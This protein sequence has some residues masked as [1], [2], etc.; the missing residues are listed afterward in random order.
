MGTDLSKICDGLKPAMV[1]VVVQIVFAG[2]NV[3]YKLATNDGMNM[4]ILVAYRY[5]FATAFVAPLAFFLERKT[6]PKLTWTVV[7]QGFLCGLFGGTLGQNLYVESLVLTSATFAS[8]MTNLI[9]AITF[10]MAIFVGLE[11]LAIR[12]L[13]GKAKVAGTVLGLGGAM[14]LTFYKGVEI[15]LWSTD[16]DLIHHNHGQGSHVAS[17][18]GESGNRVLG[19][20]LAVAS[21]LSYAVWLIIQAK[22]SA[23]YPC[24]YSSTALMCVMGSFQAVIFAICVER[25]WT[26]WKLGWNIRL[27]SVA[28]SGVIASGL[29][30]SLIAWC[31]RVRGPLFVSVFNPLMLVLVA[32]AGSF[33][34]EE[35]LHLGSILGAVLIVCG[36]YL[37]L[38]GKG[39]EVKRMTQLAPS[40][41]SRESEAI[42]VIVTS[43]THNNNKN[44]NMNTLIGNAD[45]P[46]SSALNNPAVVGTGHCSDTDLEAKERDSEEILKYRRELT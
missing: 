13:R 12:T 38:W 21:C 20:L 39:K 35:K 42:E 44:N 36:L 19:S 1:M 26:Q 14:L 33:L 30:V 24:Q 15:N 23:R 34:L 37:V 6:R 17:A 46:A 40:K 31:I 9:P 5:L 32:L 25:D 2:M 11:K 18:D 28:Y 10:I 7:F 29:I 8:A 43:T 16:I 41:S 22:M 4:R 45:N 27:L 3:F